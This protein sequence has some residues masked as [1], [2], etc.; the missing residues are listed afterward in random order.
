MY[1][2]CEGVRTVG[3]HDGSLIELPFLTQA[4]EWKLILPFNRVSITFYIYHC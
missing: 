3:T 1:R 4:I 2:V